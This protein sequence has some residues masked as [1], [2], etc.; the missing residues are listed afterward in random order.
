M[1]CEEEKFKNIV[2][3]NMERLKIGVCYDDIIF[4]SFVDKFNFNSRSF[5]KYLK[6]I[7]SF[8]RVKTNLREARELQ[9]QYDNKNIC[10]TF[11]NKD[12]NSK[13]NVY[14]LKTEYFAEPKYKDIGTDPIDI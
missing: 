1:V 10:I 13:V 12:S 2:E 9:K 8:K 4:P 6:Q 3:M 5:I 7:C 14:K 11:Y